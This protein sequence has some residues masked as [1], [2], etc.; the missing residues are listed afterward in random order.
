RISGSPWKRFPQGTLRRCPSVA[1]TGK[2]LKIDHRYATVKCETYP[3]ISSGD[4]QKMGT[5]SCLPFTVGLRYCRMT[6]QAHLMSAVG[7]LAGSKRNRGSKNEQQS[8]GRAAEI[9]QEQTH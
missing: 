6:A 7:V 2:E 4:W 3:R 8:V 5:S 1:R 9:A